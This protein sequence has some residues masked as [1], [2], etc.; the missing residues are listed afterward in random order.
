MSDQITKQMLL[1]KEQYLIPCV[2]HFYRDPMVLERG[3]GC[4]L[5][6][7][8]GKQYLDCYSGVGVTSCGHSNPE[9]IRSSIAQLKKLQH[10]T[11]IYLTEPMLRLAEKLAEF[12]PGSCK[13]SFFCSSGSEANEGALLLSK[14]ATGRNEFLALSRGL[15]GRTYLTAGVTGIEFWRTD[16]DPPQNV[17]FAPS[18]NCNNCPYKLEHPDCGLR[19]AEE[20]EHILEKNPDKVAA[21]IAEPIH[22]NGGIIV[23]PEGY[24]KRVKEI[25]D[26][27]NVLLIMDEAQTGFCRT[28]KRFG[29]E[30]HC[31]QP[32]IITVCKA[33]GNG[34]PISAFIA[35][36]EV[37]E[38]YSRP[39]ASTFGGNLVCAV[40]ALAVLQ[41]MQVQKLEQAADEKGNDLKIFLNSLQDRFASIK[42]VR[43]LGLMLG[44]ELVKQDGEPDA[45]LMDNLLENLKNRGFLVGK[46]GPGRN[47]LTLMPPLVIN[48]SEITS[49]KSG[50]QASFEACTG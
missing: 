27:H 36:D 44:I 35:T 30:Q 42:E 4:Y 20:V 41:F 38:K 25:L 10:T 2:Y 29:F 18:P 23:P 33:L 50:L 24:F 39:G 48:Q 15:H 47:V 34:M 49:L 9:I 16:P 13:K 19:C 8:E 7:T 22:G 21:M 26:K 11:T 3:E 12:I 28:G 14:L 1:L 46:T 43:G 32:D 40:T 31:I 45:E 37:A 5:F 17:H 6:D